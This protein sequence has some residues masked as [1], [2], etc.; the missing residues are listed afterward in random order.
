MK[1]RCMLILV[2]FLLSVTAFAQTNSFPSSGKVGIGTV[3]PQ[4]ALEVSGN[5]NSN[6]ISQSGATYI[7]LL[8]K[9]W[10]GGGG[11]LF[12][13]YGADVLVNGSIPQT[14]NTKNKFSPNVFGG[15]SHGPGMI[16]YG[17]NSGTM[18][19]YVGPSSPG[20]DT[21]VV[22]GEPVLSLNRS[23]NVGIGVN[24]P[25]AKLAVDGIIKTKEVNVTVSGWPDYVFMPGYKLMP[26]SDLEAFIRKN[27]HLPD[28]PTESEVMENGVNLAEMNVK[29]LEKV[30][31]LTLYAIQQDELLKKVLE[32]LSVV[33]SKLIG[34]TVIE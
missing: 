8:Q 20:A 17:G 10:G 5:Q 26:L 12:S 32:R 2:V 15:S 11:I 4:T 18:N 3:N 31:E 25:S 7:E 19:F 13:A 21:D 16:Y 29:L 34:E 30:E 33:E 6:R 22:W 24:S 1:S 27:G 28:V 14:G 9:T 23:G